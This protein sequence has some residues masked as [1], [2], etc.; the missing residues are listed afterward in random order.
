L[1]ELEER[2]E[3][4][5]VVIGVHTAKFPA[6]RD[7]RHLAAAVER[8]DLIHPVINDA[9]FRIWQSFAVRAWP[10]LMF[11]DP[12]G[13]VIGKHEGEITAEDLIPLLDAMLTEFRDAGMLETTPAPGLRS[14]SA[15]PSG[16]LSF[17]SGVLADGDSDRLYISNTNGH[18]IIEA[19]LDGDVVRCLGFGSAAGFEDGIH[20]SAAFRNPQ[21]LALHNGELYVADTGNHAIRRVDLATGVVTTVAGTG[22]LARG[23][24][25]GGQR[26]ET[27]LRS[28]W[29]LT[30]IDNTL[31]IAM[32]GSH[33]IWMHRMGTDE[34]RRGIGSGH[35]GLKDAPI[36]GAWLAQPS[37]IVSY[38][39]G[40]MLLI[41]DS[42]TSA[43]RVADL[44]GYGDGTVR[45]LVGE[46]LFEFGDIDGTRDIARLQHALGVAWHAASEM[47]YIADT[48][49][50]KI[51]RLDPEAGT[52]VNLLGDGEPGLRDGV[53]TEARFFEPSSLSITGD[54]L[55]VADTNNHAIR[56]V[57][58]VS[59]EVTTVEL[60]GLPG[61]WW[62]SKVE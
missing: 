20:Q 54:T 48:Y 12:A 11:I 5:L 28:P 47:I 33:Q 15:L 58:L 45:T 59:G 51:K 38:G 21:G 43:I 27:P 8:L 36:A 39:D 61:E 62:K 29:D 55:F 41:A 46:D 22:K 13:Q 19:T 17:P 4:E 10:T 31:W 24:S 2:Y 53:G 44:P 52:I 60:R 37:G 30:V 6:E 3:D 49:N 35:E 57:D 56:R 25:S 23:Y 9:E 14:D 16:S 40:R 7:D 42:E 26:L 18:S 1:R 50:N 34:I 32:A